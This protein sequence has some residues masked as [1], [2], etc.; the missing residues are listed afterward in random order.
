MA[1]TASKC[2]LAQV[3]CCERKEM[4][5]DLD[6]PSIPTQ[7]YVYNCEGNW[8]FKQVSETMQNTVS[9]FFKRKLVIVG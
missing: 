9:F 1:A 3:G 4:L 2:S 7:N 6:F 5:K 8:I